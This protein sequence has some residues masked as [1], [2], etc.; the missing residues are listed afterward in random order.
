MTAKLQNT[1]KL[2]LNFSSVAIVDFFFLFSKLTV[3]IPGHKLFM[4]FTFIFNHAF[5]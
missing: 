5:G 3:L 4:M 2:D 1:E